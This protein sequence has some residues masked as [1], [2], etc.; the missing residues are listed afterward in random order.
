MARTKPAMGLT[1]EEI[2]DFEKLKKGA[3]AEQLRAMIDD[4]QDELNTKQPK[5]DFGFGNNKGMFQ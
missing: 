1:S 3:N 4:L 5:Q 2:S